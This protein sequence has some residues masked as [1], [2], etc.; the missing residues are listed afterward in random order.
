MVFIISG[1]WHNHSLTSDYWDFHLMASC[2][3]RDTFSCVKD[4]KTIHLAEGAWRGDHWLTKEFRMWVSMT[5]WWN[6]QMSLSMVIMLLRSVFQNFYV[7]Q[8]TVG[9]W[10]IQISMPSPELKRQNLCGPCGHL[11][12]APS[13]FLCRNKLKEH[14][15]YRCFFLPCLFFPL[16]WAL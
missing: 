3:W 9:L 14:K 16:R 1:E 15:D 5:I 4:S 10:L 7:W 2:P 8:T 12:I 11:T 6:E 13:G